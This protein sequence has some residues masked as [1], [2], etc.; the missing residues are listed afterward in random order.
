MLKILY[1]MHIPWGWSKQRPQFI[2][3]ELAKHFD[4]T[5]LS[6][7]NYASKKV[8][9]TVPSK[10][11]NIHEPFRIPF[12]RYRLIFHINKIIYWFYFKFL[13][14]NHIVWITDPRA[15]ERI[16][17]AIPKNTN[18]IYDCMDDVLAFNLSP[19]VKT[20][21]S[22]LEQ[23]L[24]SSAQF[25]FCSSETLLK[26]LK[27][28]Y[29]DKISLKSEVVNNALSDKKFLHTSKTDDI[30]EIQTV[31]SEARK[32]DYIICTYIGTISD[33]FDFEL[34]LESLERNAKVCYFLF[35][36]T[37][38]TIP[39]HPRLIFFGAIKH[40]IVFNVMALSD[41]LVMPFLLT[42][43]I[44]SVD[45]V[46][47]YEYIAS[48]K[49]VICL[50]YPES[51]KFGE[52]LKYYKSIESYMIALDKAVASKILNDNVRITFVKNHNWE[53]RVI[54]IVTKIKILSSKCT[55]IQ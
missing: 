13:F 1:I 19:E 54:P 41:I 6:A 47:L 15:Y 10:R 11:L 52:L 25:I 12:E 16:V 36:H 32:K 35:G 51:E 34:I 37:D 50:Q 38:V 24:V 55:L 31:F 22:I 43:L 42:P 18:I 30:S 3:E 45:A 33:W 2:A 39:K 40:E 44:E 14:N 53:K 5:V 49:P 28:R 20:K 23:E 21:I 4:V 27:T 9:E 17:N 8:N 7:K 29:G 26:R 48:G 46:K